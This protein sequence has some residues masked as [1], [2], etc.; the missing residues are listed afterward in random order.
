MKKLLLFSIFCVVITFTTLAQIPQRAAHAVKSDATVQIT[1]SDLGATTCTFT[2]TKNSDCAYYSFCAFTEQDIAQWVGMF[3]MT[4]EQLVSAWGIR[5][6][7]DTTYTYTG[8]TPG[9]QYTVFALPFGADSVATDI[10]SCVVN[11]TT[12]GGS[13]EA[14]IDITVSEIADTSA[15]TLCTPNENTAYYHYGIVE[16]EYYNTNGED[17]LVAFFSQ[18]QTFYETSDWVWLT[19]VPATEYYV[20]AFGFNNQ[21]ERGPISLYPFTTLSYT[22]I[23][24]FK[25]GGCAIFPNPSHGEFTLLSHN[26]PKGRLNIFSLQGQLMYSQTLTGDENR[27]STNLPAGTYPIQISNSNGKTIYTGKLI[28][29]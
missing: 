21:D 4:I 26:L 7:H 2:F 20:M 12:Q 8:W 19:L 14:E 6:D 17:A 23:D 27:I 16:Q 29:Q 11:T 28:I 25:Q 3:G 15:R 9:T 5:T 18:D 22:G 13:G 10:V 1:F 24:E